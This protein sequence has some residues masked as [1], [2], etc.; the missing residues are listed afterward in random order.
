MSFRKMTG[1]FALVAVTSAW[2]ILFFALIT[3]PAKEDVTAQKSTATDSAV[4]QMLFPSDGAWLTATVPVTIQATVTDSLGLQDMPV[5]YMQVGFWGVNSTDIAVV[6]IIDTQTQILSVP[7]VTLTEG[8]GN[9]ITF[10]V[11]NNGAPAQY[12]SHTF[13]VRQDSVAPTGRVTWPTS[14][15]V[16]GSGDTVSVTWDVTDV[17][18]GM[19]ST[20]VWFQPSPSSV[21]SYVTTTTSNNITWTVSD[22]ANNSQAKIILNVLDMAGNAS[23]IESQPFTLLSPLTRR[24][25]LPYLNGSCANQASDWCEP[26]NTITTAFSLALNYEITASINMT[27]DRYD[28]YRIRFDNV[29]PYTVTLHVLPPCVDYTGPICDLDVY[30]YK[31]APPFDYV[32][33]SATDGAGNEQFEFTPTTT[34]PTGT[35]AI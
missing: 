2:A 26:N 15:T 3:V 8:L 20:Q 7:N 22:A 1:R 27:S 18:S 12:I 25:Y 32:T 10:S 17:S 13:S 24:A 33:G 29:K 34:Y 21:P 30:M 16:W 6:T 23:A 28:W 4:W 14:T 9:V 31:T 19:N 5:Y 35:Y 11:L